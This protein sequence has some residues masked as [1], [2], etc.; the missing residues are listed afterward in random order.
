MDFLEILDSSLL[1]VECV[2]VV[3]VAVCQNIFYI[4]SLV[5]FFQPSLCY[6]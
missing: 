3:V 1:G 5:V 2:V 6:F 4:L